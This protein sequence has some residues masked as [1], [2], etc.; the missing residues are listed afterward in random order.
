M[1]KPPWAQIHYI[2]ISDTSL[3]THKSDTTP[4]CNNSAS[5]N[6]NNTS[7]PSNILTTTT[8]TTIAANST[9]SLHVAGDH[10]CLLKTAVANVYA[11]DTG[12]VAIILLD[13][14]SQRSFLTESLAKSLRVQTHHT[15]EICLAASFGSPTTLVKRLDIGTIYLETIIGER[16]P[17]SVLIVPTIAA[18]MHNTTDYTINRLPYL[19]GLQLAHP[20]TV[21]EQFEVALLIGADHYWQVV[22]DHLVRGPGPTAVK[23][24]LGYLLSGPLVPPKRHCKQLVATVLHVSE[25]LVQDTE[26]FWTTE[27]ATISPTL[28][29]PDKEFMTEYQRTCIRQETNGS[30]TA[31]FPWKP[32][33]PPLPSNL[34]LCEERTR[35]LAHR[36]AAS[37]NLLT[38]YNNILIDQERRGFIEKINSPV[39]SSYSHYIPHHA[40][41]KES[42]TTPIRIVYDCS[43]HQSKTLPSLNDCLRL[44]PPSF[45]ICVRLLFD[46]VST[47][48][49]SPQTSK[50]HFYMSTYTKTTE[51]SQDSCGF[52]THQIPT[53]SLWF[54]DLR[55]CCS[56][57]PVLHSSWIQLCIIIYHI[58]PPS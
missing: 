51:T 11:N 39:V 16:L 8:M 6:S 3:C 20:V 21:R 55:S 50:K 38:T 36:L 1:V 56:E 53:V 24:K 35:A 22:E 37:P 17:L 2:C 45:K 29:N 43:C 18:P 13:E 30:Y 19:K 46:F 49:L 33:H 26:L 10:V 31:R 28:V 12:I 4:Q 15:E 32:N 34:T 9:T 41:K 44:V 54:I 58:T 42:A 47:D 7:S 48:L 57:L 27:S 40:V 52:Q 23:S 5:Q 25:Q 14:G